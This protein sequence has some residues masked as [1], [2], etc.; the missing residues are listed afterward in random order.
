MSAVGAVAGYVNAAVLFRFLCGKSGEVAGHGV[1]RALSASHEIE[2]YRRELQRCAALQKQDLVAVRHVQ[3]IS[4]LPFG[5][6][7]NFAEQ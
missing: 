5:F 4:E 3:G 2:G 1:V 6:R 7:K